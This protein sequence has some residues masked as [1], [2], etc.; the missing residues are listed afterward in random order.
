MPYYFMLVEM[1]RYKLRDIVMPVQADGTGEEE[2]DEGRRI[3]HSIQEPIVLHLDPIEFEDEE[4]I[5]M[6]AMFKPPL[7]FR[8]DLLEDLRK[9]GVDNIDSYDCILRD[10]K[11]NEEWKNYKLCN[12]IGLIDVFD[13]EA[14]EL[15]E[16]SPSEVAYLF[17]EIVID[18]KKGRGHH[19]F[20]PYGRMTQLLVSDE[21]KTYLE[22]KEKYQEIGF[23]S[24]ENFA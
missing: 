9:F 16:D 4:Y 24:P 10:P 22:S 15:H 11:T 8:D 14:S 13:M 1:D 5:N 23:I 18:D 2:F 19:L 21:L 12:V 20:R 3:N 6:G 7:V 17:N